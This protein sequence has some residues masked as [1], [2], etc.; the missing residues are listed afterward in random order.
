MVIYLR[1]ISTWIKFK[2]KLIVIKW[3]QVLHPF[4]FHTLKLMCIHWF[5]CMKIT[6]FGVLVQ[7]MVLD[8]WS[9]KFSR[10]HFVWFPH[11]WFVTNYRPLTKYDGRLCFS[12]FTPGGGTPSPSYNTSTGPMFFLGGTPSPPHNTSTGPMSFLGGYPSDWSQVPLGE[13]N[14]VPGGGYPCPRQVYTPVSRWDTL[15]LT[16]GYP[17]PTRTGWV[18]IPPPARSGCGTTP[19]PHGTGYAWTGYATS[20]T[21]LTVPCRRNVLFMGGEESAS[22]GDPCFYITE[23]KGKRNFSLIFRSYFVWIVP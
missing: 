11:F 20:G 9:P 19:T 5:V 14:P 21:A 7:G 1:G 16:R 15:V 8:P 2:W 3:K 12:L 23:R 4:K 22:C 18:T 17:L 10:Y 6:Q 13:G